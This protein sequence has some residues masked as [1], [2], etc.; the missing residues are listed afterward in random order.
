MRKWIMPL[1]AG[2]VVGIVAYKVILNRYF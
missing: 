1:L 2:V